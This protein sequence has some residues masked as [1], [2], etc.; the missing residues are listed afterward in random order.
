MMQRNELL[1]P[2]NLGSKLV[3]VTYCVNL[4]KLLNVSESHT[5]FSGMV[6]TPVA[7]ELP[8]DCA[9]VVLIL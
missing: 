4:G 2:G 1:T 6:T 9:W 8:Q 7:A 3:S 5:W